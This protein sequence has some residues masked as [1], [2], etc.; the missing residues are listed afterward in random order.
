MAQ[1][2]V[3]LPAIMLLKILVKIKYGIL[4]CI[5]IQNN[6]LHHIQGIIL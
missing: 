5:W 1:L 3:T 6:P 2:F 4:G